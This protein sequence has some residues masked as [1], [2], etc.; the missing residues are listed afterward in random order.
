MTIFQLI[1]F[2]G[3]MMLLGF[4]LA[5][6]QVYF[7]WNM[8]LPITKMMVVC[9]LLFGYVGLS[10]AYGNPSQWRVLIGLIA[11]IVDIVVLYQIRQMMKR[12]DVAFYLEK[13]REKV[14]E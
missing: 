2:S 1:L 4:N 12:G 8:H 14:R 10:A 3:S 9:C 13:L 7:R 11:M 6:L 5:M